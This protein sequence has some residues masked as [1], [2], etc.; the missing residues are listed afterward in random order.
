LVLFSVLTL[1]CSL[2]L[3]EGHS[4]HRVWLSHHKTRP[5]QTINVSL[6]HILL[7]SIFRHRF[8]SAWQT[9]GIPAKSSPRCL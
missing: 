9:T 6:F 1:L 3:G 8:T 7:E 4:Q 5:I 2:S